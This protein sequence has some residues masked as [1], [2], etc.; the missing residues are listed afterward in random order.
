MSEEGKDTTVCEMNKIW[1]L[2]VT[3][4]ESNVRLF[5]L[6]GILSLAA[7]C[8]LLGYDEPLV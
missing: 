7:F 2:V 1:M 5:C 6:F 3:T 4:A 8:S